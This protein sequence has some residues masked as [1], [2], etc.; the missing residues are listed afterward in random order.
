MAVNTW[1]GASDT[2]W[3][4]AAN[5]NT[6]GETDRIPTAADDVV[7]A[8]VSNNCVMPDGLNPTINSLLVESSASLTA[9]NNNITIDSHPASGTNRP[10]D[11]SG[12]FVK[13]TSTLTFTY[14]AAET[15][16]L[17]FR[18]VE[19]HNVV[20]NGAN[21]TFA[22]GNGALTA[23]GDLTITAG[24]LDTFSAQNNA[25][26]VTGDVTCAGNL[27]CN[28]SAVQCDS[29]KTTGGTVN[30]P[31][32]SGSFTV[33]GTNP[34][35]YGIEDTAGS[36]NIVH[37]SG[38]VTW[39]TG[40]LSTMYAKS[41]FNN[42]TTATSSTD[43][44]WFGTLTLAGTLI[45]AANTDV[46]EHPTA[47]GAFT[48]NGDVSVSGTIGDSSANSAYSFGSLTI[49]S[50]GT[51]KATSGTTTI[52]NE[53]S[54]GLAM[55]NDG[56]FTHNNGTVIITTSSNSQIDWIGSS[57][58]LNN[59]TY[60]GGAIL[61]WTVN[62]GTI[63]GNLS[64]TNGTLQSSNGNKTLTVTGNVTVGD[65]TGSA[66]TAILGNASEAAA[67]TFGSLTIDSDGKYNA[68]S[69]TTTITNETS[70][71]AWKNDGGTFTHNSG[72]VKFDLEN[73]AGSSSVKEN[74]FYDVEI[75]MFASTYSLS[76]FDVSG[77]AVTILNNLDITKG[78]MD[79]STA[80][81]TITIHGLTKIAAD[82]T[83]SDNAA[84][85]TDKIIHNGL[86]TNSGT[87][88]INDGTTVKM[89]GG[90]RNLGTITGA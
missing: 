8:N 34:S 16:Y 38:T 43:L 69:A 46:Y 58:N 54:S 11:L 19:V 50:G 64:I 18:G 27:T 36:G 68:T 70:G 17:N 79:F 62:G 10:I 3:N 49:A 42:I 56:T 37:N 75:D 23:S 57:G 63:D 29:L 59:L 2:N 88:K 60:S 35:G 31:D 78:E 4:D 21:T 45:V 13:G 61:E 33:K 67:Q 25:I 48:V 65:G 77:N 7:I 53:N 30:L 89:N 85:D 32:G 80:S 52:T 84:H 20:I 6:T 66:N 28:S 40:G 73:S 9:G 90:I 39:D 15:K 81:D 82:G 47:G 76:F 71:H 86:V 5:W 51:Y 83:F 44:R 1:D 55:D 87:Y 74:E 72:K 24:T 12:T 41:T 14:S 26:T 22:I